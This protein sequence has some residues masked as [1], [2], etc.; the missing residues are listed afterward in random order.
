[1]SL[2][3]NRSNRERR[4]KTAVTRMEE[5]VENHSE[6]WRGRQLSQE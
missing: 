2:L 3:D 1:M 4:K 6:I 5:E